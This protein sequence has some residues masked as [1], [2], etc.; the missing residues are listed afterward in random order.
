M[1][2]GNG[3]PGGL[4]DDGWHVAGGGRVALGNAAIL[5]RFLLLLPKESVPDPLVGAKS[6][7]LRFRRQAAP[8]AENCAHSLAPPLKTELAALDFGFV[9][10]FYCSHP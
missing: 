5:G 3:V 7:R 10:S 1:L 2:R 4:P 6:V 8:Y 9:F